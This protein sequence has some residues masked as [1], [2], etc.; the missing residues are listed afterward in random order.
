MDI[1]NQ[2]ICP[3]ETCNSSYIG[4]SSRCLENRIKEHNNSTIS[5]IYQ[6]RSTYNHPKAD[7]SHFKITDQDSKQVSREARKAI[8]IR[9]TNPV[10]N[11]NIGKMYIPNIF[12][13]LLGATRHSTNPN[14]PKIPNNASVDSSTTSNPPK[15]HSIRSTRAVCLCN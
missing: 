7:I 10:L 8:Q 14:N 13:Q 1:V 11:Y 9:R 15:T 4:E 6:H 12:N 5:A 3:E 2:W